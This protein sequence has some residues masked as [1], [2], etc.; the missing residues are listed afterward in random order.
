MKQIPSN[1]QNLKL[2]LSGNE[3]GKNT[4]NMKFLGEGMQQVPNNLESFEL[5]LSSN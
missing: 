1:L 2:D 3:L 5:D 4:D